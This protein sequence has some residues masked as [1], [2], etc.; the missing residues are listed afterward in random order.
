MNSDRLQQGF[1]AVL[2]FLLPLAFF[3]G[4]SLFPISVI[5]ANDIQ[6]A[7]E[8]NILL[9]KLLVLCILAI[10]VWR[11]HL[12]IAWRSP[13][14]WL[15]LG[16]WLFVTFSTMIAED[17]STFKLLGGQY[18]MDG[19]LY[20]TALTSLGIGM[21]SLGLTNQKS[22]QVFIS[23][24]LGG[25]VIQ[26]LLMLLQRWNIDLI[27]P[28]TR[29][30][31]NSA[32][33]GTLTHPGMIAA[34][35]MCGL[36]LGIGFVT[37]VS[38]KVRSWWYVGLITSTIG[39][40]ITNNRASLY[41]IF[42]ALAL[43]CLYQRNRLTVILSISSLILILGVKEILPNPQGFVRSL[44]DSRSFEVRIHIWE[45]AFSALENMKWQP[46]LGGG[47]DGFRLELLRNPPIK[48]Y[49]AA[50]GAELGW[51]KN[52]EINSVTREERDPIRDTSLRVTFSHF[53]EKTGY[54]LEV[55]LVLDRAHSLLLDRALSYGWFNA[56]I[57][58][59]LYGYPIWW[60]FRYWKNRDLI[61][62]AL[63]FTILGLF[64]YYLVWFP[65]MQVEPIHMAILAFAWARL[66]IF[67]LSKKI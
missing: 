7:V 53:N 35:L 2:A 21:Y 65:V 49:L 3:P 22:I 30:D 48:S 34:L 9:P 18:R 66:S 57:W 11:L 60:A 61:S 1:V 25:S 64:T 29:F 15:L 55:P 12:K 31:T 50:Y 63:G 32:P 37:T 44:E 38:T 46:L 10:A 58:L 45:S 24:L 39:L 26:V 36:L 47:P 16:H 62:I 17:E 43:I 56:T 59:I 40:S 52:A 28:L 23:G 42:V 5:T 13:F 19:W 54:T 8:N 20:Q 33:I 27:T 41:G 6:F 67:K 4:A 14:V 51:P